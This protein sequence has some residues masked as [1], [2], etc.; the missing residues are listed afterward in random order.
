MPSTHQCQPVSGRCL[1]RCGGGGEEASVQPFE[2]GEIVTFAATQEDG[3]VQ[4]S[5][6]LMHG[7]NADGDLLTGQDE[8]A[9]SLKIST[10]P[11]KRPPLAGV[12][13]ALPLESGYSPSESVRLPMH[14]ATFTCSC[15][16]AFPSVAT[17]ARTLPLKLAI[18]IPTLPR[19]TRITSNP[20]LPASKT[21]W[22]FT[23][24]WAKN[25]FFDAQETVEEELLEFFYATGSR[26]SQL[27][28]TLA[29]LQWTGRDF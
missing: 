3:S 11:G 19:C 7:V 4:E 22:C 25:P 18:S 26:Q 6:Y 28:Q 2:P 21:T 10:G 9:S 15:G 8:Q 23:S 27:L 29:E 5:H 24:R 13:V 12:L 16:A 17:M 14:C 20:V 1:D